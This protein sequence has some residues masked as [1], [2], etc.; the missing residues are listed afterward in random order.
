MKSSLFQLN[1][2][3]HK[4]FEFLRSKESLIL[5]LGQL[6][7]Y[8]IRKTFVVNYAKNMHQKL[9]PD[10]YSVLLNTQKYS[11]CIQQIIF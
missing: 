11:Q 7:K 8:R 1:N 5:K 2:Q 3:K 9:V 10:L 4:L 6:I